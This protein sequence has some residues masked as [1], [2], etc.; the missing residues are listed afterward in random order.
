MECLLD[1]RGV[2]SDL[3]KSTVVGIDAL[4][5]ALT[6]KVFLCPSK[7]VKTFRGSWCDTNTKS[8]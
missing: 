3:P 7:K 4:G 1:G 8:D 5:M 6:L 2:S